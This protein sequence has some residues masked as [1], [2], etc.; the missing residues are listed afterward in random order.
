MNQIKKSLQVILPL[1]LAAFLFWL[2]YKDWDFSSLGKVFNTGTNYEWFVIS[3]LISILSMILRG[4]RWHQMLEPVC[5]QAQ[6]KHAILGIFIA[7]AANLL[8][9]RAGEVARCGILKKADGVS[10]TKSLGTVI[11][12]RAIDVIILFFITFITVVIQ[13]DV[14]SAFFYKNPDSLTKLQQLATSPLLWGGLIG[15]V[16]IIA[17][18]WKP[19]SRR[20]FFQKIQAIVI[21]LWIGMKSIMTLKSPFLFLLYSFGIWVCYFI[22]FYIVLYFFDW[23][24]DLGVPAMLSGFVMG[25]Y[26]VVAPVQGGL[27]AYHFMVIYTLVFYGVSEVDAGIFALVAHGLQ[28]VYTLITGLIAYLLF[29]WMSKKNPKLA[30]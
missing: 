21:Q 20:P 18:L 5:P 22:N 28:T 11:T 4:L 12:E 10:F 13:V 14:F 27:G 15:S 1:L 17:L 6:K 19:M 25:S 8:L 7:Y 29:L 24:L 30:S 16:V 23:N 3:L 26:G 9:P 2:V